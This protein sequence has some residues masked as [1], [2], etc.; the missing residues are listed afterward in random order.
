MLRAVSSEDDSVT[1]KH[2]RTNVVVDCLETKCLLLRRSRSSSVNSVSTTETCNSSINS[3]S[4]SLKTTA[5][6]NEIKHRKRR[7]HF[8]STAEEYAPSHCLP[9]NNGELWYAEKDFKLFRNVARKEVSTYCLQTG[10]VE[11]LRAVYEVHGNMF[12]AQFVY[13][14]HNAQGASR[15]SYKENMTLGRAVHIVGSGLRGLEVLV[16]KQMSLDRKA[17]LKRVLEMQTKLPSGLSAN[18]RT[19]AIAAKA[20]YLSRQFRQFAQVQGRA[21]TITVSAIAAEKV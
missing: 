3:S 8:G 1:L 4:R 21:D 20:R 18:E 5:V 14:E 12:H 15:Q 10:V 13:S 11:E 7:V 9:G 19:I 6:Q 17:V 16:L 2:N